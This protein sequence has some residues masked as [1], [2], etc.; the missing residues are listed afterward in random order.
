VFFVISGFV[1]TAMLQREWIRSGRIR[2]HHFYMKRFKRLTPALALMVTVTLI[3]S[4]FILG[5]LGPQQV[6]AQTG[7]GAMLL[8][9]NF[10]INRTTGGYFDMAAETNPLINTWS[11]SVEEQFYLVFPAVIALGWYLAHRTARF[12]AAPFFFISVIAGFS[13]ILTLAGSF[14]LTFSGSGWI[15]GFYSPFTRAWEFAVGALLALA[16]AKAT[17]SSSSRL[18]FVVAGTGVSML[19]ASLWLITEAT[20]F[21]GLWTL[22]PV[23]GTLLLLFAG[24]SQNSVSRAI[25]TRPMVKI[26]DWSYSIYL[27]HWPFIAFALYLWP[28]NPYTAVL[29]AAVSLVPALASYYWVEQPI[30]S[31]V[32]LGPRRWSILVG[33]SLVVPITCG[34]ILGLGAQQGWGS[35]TIREFQAEIRQYHIGQNNG[36]D[37]QSPVG[38]NSA[39]CTWNSQLDGEPIYL[40]GDSNSDH[41]GEAVMGAAEQ[42]GRPFKLSWF[43]SC[44]FVYGVLIDDSSTI[45]H[46]D[47]CS[48]YVQGIKEY[49]N[50]APAGLV[51]IA[52]NDRYWERQQFRFG[53]SKQQATND[54]SQKIR[55]FRIELQ[56]TTEALQAAGHQVLF[57]Q[58]VPTWDDFGP[59]DPTR[60]TLISIVAGKCVAQQSLGQ[61]QESK[62]SIR[63]KIEEV[64]A[65]TGASIWDPGRD[66]C[67]EGTCSTQGPEYLRYRDT[68]HISV[69]QSI[70]LIPMVRD[71]LSNLS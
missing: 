68:V 56:D 10:V 48:N 11:L 20:I 19:V 2:F 50:K 16:L 14:G 29:A 27:W 66:L 54:A 65:V 5:P 67:A 60:C 34:G 18:I 31:S 63:S 9:A 23:T 3:G 22:L 62:S 35:E 45:S 1:I 25:G 46:N 52:N 30:R 6:A 37:S 42:M 26:G 44:P 13:F 53:S 40:V 15:F 47:A 64:A 33:V 55:S 57:V 12:C 39:N 17:P 70:A 41:F 21:P 69:S 59:W 61:A 49:L 32:D 71:L 38:L 43:S 28:F 8:A 7:I 51:I 4:A 36:C 58:T 24:T